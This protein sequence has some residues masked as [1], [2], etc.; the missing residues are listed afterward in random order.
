MG[1]PKHSH[2]ID[3]TQKLSI[4]SKHS[5]DAST[6]NSTGPNMSTA[7]FIV[8]Q[9]MRFIISHQLFESLLIYQYMYLNEFPSYSILDLTGHHSIV[10]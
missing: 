9:V 1:S 7:S 5:S 3:G 6:T 8:N 10:N 2:M 4:L